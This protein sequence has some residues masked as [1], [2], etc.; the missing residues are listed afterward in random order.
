M[1]E[2]LSD[3]ECVE[4]LRLTKELGTGKAAAMLGISTRGLKQTNADATGRGLTAET[5][6]VDEAAKWRTKWQLISREL[7]VIRRDNLTAADIRERIY[8]LAALTPDPPGWLDVQSSLHTPGVPITVWSDWHWGE[9]INKAQVGGVNEFNRTIAK[10]RLKKLVDKTIDLCMNHMTKP[11]YPGIVICLGGDMISGVIHEELRETNDG[12]VQQHLLEVQEQ[13]ISAI[14]RMA[15]TFGRVFIP[16]VVGNHARTTIKP[17]AKNRV[18]ESYEWNLYCQLESWFKGDKR[19]QFYIPEGTDAY[20]K[21][22]GHRI[23]LTHGDSLG[24]KGGDG[25]IGA[26]GPIARGAVKVGRSEAQVGRDFDTL[27]MGHWHTYWPRGE[28]APVVVNG[29]L[30]GYDEYARLMLRVPYSRPSQALFFVH[31]KQGITA[32][33]QVYLEERKGAADS[34]WITWKKAA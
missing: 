28:C 1:A 16:C 9:V 6:V 26:I 3:A 25:I 12:T 31:A 29:A 8:G 27:V 23:L 20:F 4:R 18:V 34:A 11:E 13:L 30:K 7:A 24:V 2:K 33:W 22:L 32:Q 15:D 5:K 17:R 21:V 10:Q 14:T 19:V